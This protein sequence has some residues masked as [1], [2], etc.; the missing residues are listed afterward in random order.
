MN[1]DFFANGSAHGSVASKLVASGMSIHALRPF[2]GKDGRPYMSVLKGGKLVAQ[3]IM[4][5]ATLRKDEW[6]A[7][8]QALLDITQQRLVGIAD[9]ISMGLTHNL[10]NGLG[11]TVLEYEDL[12]DI[13]EAD[14]SMDG[15]NRGQNDRPNYELKYLP[16]PIVHKDFQINARALTASRT[17]GD[18]LDTTMAMKSG[19][20]VSDKLEDML[21]NGTSSYSFGGGTIYGYT[22]FPNRNTGSLFAAWDDGTVPSG[23]SR[24]EAILADVQAMKQAAIDD[25]YYGP[26]TLY[27]PTHY[28]TTLDG[29]FKANSDKTIRARIL[30]IENVNMIK[31]ADSLT[32]GTDQVLL[33]QMTSD[34]V[35]LV[36]G[37]APTTLQWDVEGGMAV[38]FKIMAIQV[39]QIRADQDGNCGV[40]HY[41]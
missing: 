18:A 26:Y 25:G 29:D 36:N 5:N 6:K 24:G 32:A 11:K 9:L 2:I 17:T 40:I 39:P 8:D 15:L 31:I 22:D 28:E 20:K 4:A 3:P 12:G 7:Y 34:V 27:I 30:E 21:F 14:L 38:N 16:L 33:V 13:N 1:T 10:T 35:R 41:T 37:M 23:L 19:R